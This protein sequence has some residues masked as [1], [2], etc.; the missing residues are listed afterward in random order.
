VDESSYQPSS[1][2]KMGDHPVVWTNEKMKAR[3]I[4]IQMGHHPSLLTNEN[5]TTLLRNAILWAGGDKIGNQN[6]A[7]TTNS[8]TK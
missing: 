2:I 6:G 4:Y 3:N 7:N 5:Y 1:D 8:V